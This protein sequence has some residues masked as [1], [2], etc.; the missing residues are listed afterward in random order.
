MYIQLCNAST[1]VLKQF[2]DTRPTL[3][4]SMTLPLPSRTSSVSVWNPTTETIEKCVVPSKPISR[5][6]VQR[7]G[8]ANDRHASV[9]RMHYDPA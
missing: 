5:R 7:R 1:L 3:S 6:S 9:A 4:L 2:G 8:G